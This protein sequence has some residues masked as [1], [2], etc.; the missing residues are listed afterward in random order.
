[1]TDPSSG[2]TRRCVQ[3]R[4]QP[5]T[6]IPIVGQMRSRRRTR[7]FPPLRPLPRPPHSGS[8]ETM[9]SCSPS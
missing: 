6:R 4:I 1:M 5:V 8:W 3:T 7:P 9:S 2:Q